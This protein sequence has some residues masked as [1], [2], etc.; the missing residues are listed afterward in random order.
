[1][2]HGRLGRDAFEL[3]EDADL[4][5]NGLSSLASVN[6]MLAL[7]SEFAV[8]F[9]DQMLNRRVFESIGAIATALRELTG[10]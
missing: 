10:G 1:L 6:V 8:E 4:Y 9:P 7:E 3:S 2:A 5:S